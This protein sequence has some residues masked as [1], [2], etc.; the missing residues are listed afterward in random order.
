[1][2]MLKSFDHDV[3]NCTLMLAVYFSLFNL[4]LQKHICGVYL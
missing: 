4:Y 2:V 1:M 3:F